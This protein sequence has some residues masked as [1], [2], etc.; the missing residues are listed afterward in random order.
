MEIG[1]SVYPSFVATLRATALITGFLLFSWSFFLYKYEER[2]IQQTIVQWGRSVRGRRVVWTS[3]NTIGMRQVASSIGETLSGMFGQRMFSVRAFLV[4]TCLALSSFL[5]VSFAFSL[6]TWFRPVTE[7]ISGFRTFGFFVGGTFTLLGATARRKKYSE[8]TRGAVAASGVTGLS[9]F[10]AITSGHVKGFL[11]GLVVGIIC[12][13]VVVSMTRASA[14]WAVGTPHRV[15][16]ALLAI[17][18]A[19]IGVGLII[20]PILQMNTGRMRGLAADILGFGSFTN[21]FTGVIAASFAILPLI[22]LLQIIMW[23]VIHRPLYALARF[24]VFQN[25]TLLFSASCILLAFGLPQ[26]ASWLGSI[27]ALFAR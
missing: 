25:H 9:L 3:R 19:I 6:Y 24:K 7:P 10:F 23:P 16:V 11:A 13:M 27:R 8:I 14:V 15:G 22:L 21:F 20:A 17:A 5:L 18:N 26:L 1:D 4:S 12:V 2:R